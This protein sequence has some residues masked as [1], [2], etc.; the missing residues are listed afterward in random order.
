[1]ICID[2]SVSVSVYVLITESTP[3]RWDSSIVDFMVEKTI[4]IGLPSK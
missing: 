3:D 4:H 1:M 2:V